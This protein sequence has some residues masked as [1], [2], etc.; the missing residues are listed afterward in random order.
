MKGQQYKCC[1][2]ESESFSLTGQGLYL[3]C[4]YE[5]GDVFSY[6]QE[7]R[8]VY[9]AVTGTNICCTGRGR[10]A[11]MRRDEGEGE[12]PVASWYAVRF[13]VL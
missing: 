10:R 12:D 9:C 11:D 3:V 13:F 6:S 4:T 7:G 8:T 2:E 1:D 5:G